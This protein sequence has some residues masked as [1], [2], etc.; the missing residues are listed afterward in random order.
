MAAKTAHDAF[1]GLFLAGARNPLLVAMFNQA[2]GARLSNVSPK[3]NSFYDPRHLEQHQALLQALRKRDGR[4]ARA[5][6][7]KHFQS[8]GLMLQVAVRASRKA[9]VASVVPLQR[10]AAR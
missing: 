7:R 8:L 4:A 3:H 2:Q 10:R 6:V 1:H 5:V 9:P